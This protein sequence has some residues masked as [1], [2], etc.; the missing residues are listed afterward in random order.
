[1]HIRMN[2][3]VIT[4]K[5]HTTLPSTPELEHN[6]HIVYYDVADTRRVGDFNRLC[7]RHIL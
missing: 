4:M 3:G 7:S 1:M 5:R 6:H 2:L